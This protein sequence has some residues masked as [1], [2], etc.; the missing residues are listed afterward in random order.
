MGVNDA[1]ERFEE[2]KYPSN[3]HIAW[4]LQTEHST[5]V[6]VVGGKSVFRPWNSGRLGKGIHP[7]FDVLGMYFL[8]DA[9]SGNHFEAS[10]TAY[11]VLDLVK[12][13]Q[14]KRVALQNKSDG[15]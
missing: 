5:R 2:G 12:G 11:V 9:L 14:N 1:L 6:T 13:R 4:E 3:V 10:S 8:N 15:G 7:G